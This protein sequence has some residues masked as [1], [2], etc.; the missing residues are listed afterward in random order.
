[1][2]RP[3]FLKLFLG[4]LTVIIIG[5]LLSIIF[6]FKAI[7]DY[8]F[9][10]T[11]DTMVERN[12]PLQ[13]EVVHLLA[14]HRER[15]LTS[16]VKKYGALNRTRITIIDPEGTVLAD[17]VVDPATMYNHRTRLEIAEA[18]QGRI[19][20]S[21]RF[22]PDLKEE[23]IYIALP[24]RSAGAVVGVI[25]YSLKSEEISRLLRTVRARIILVSVLVAAF[26]L[27]ISFIFSHLLSQPIRKLQQAAQK[28]AGGDFTVRV[29]ISGND[30]LKDL[31]AGFN[32]MTARIKDSFSEISRKQ[33]ELQGIISSIS[34]V[35]FLLDSEG[36]VLLCNESAKRITGLEKIIGKYYWE[37]LRSSFLHDMLKRKGAVHVSEEIPLNG[38]VY[39]C[40]ASSLPSGDATV[41]ILHDITDMK[42]MEQIKQDLVVNVSHELNT[43]LTAIKGFTETL[44]EEADE[45][46]LQYLVIIKR[47]TVRLIN[48]VKDLL[49]LSELEE[50][51]S[52]LHRE[53]VNL[54]ALIENLTVIFE[55]RILAKD[56]VLTVDIPATLTLAA[57]PFWL[58]QLFTNLIDNAIKY[59]EKGEITIAAEQTHDGC[60]ISIKDTGIGISKEHLGR[61]FERFY[62]VDKSRSRS[63]GGTGL[64]LAIVKHIVALHHGEIDVESTPYLG[65]TFTITL[66]GRM[67]E[68][69]NSPDP[70]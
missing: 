15:E 70:L 63:V 69:F 6:S 57:D 23:M 18:L 59:T 56:L 28:V 30:E 32:Q 12:R 62:V 16:L 20:R 34:E 60:R 11:T 1:M 24:V 14:E 4:F 21:V 26:S 61:I 8:Y 53:T 52:V 51:G 54:R 58:E 47:H 44:I 7:R 64:G 33:E 46:Q 31:A 3:I 67:S 10:S 65:T 22:S 37:L 27:I 38:R 19:G 29:P 55:P 42:Q 36:R 2:K 49:T 66:P 5:S 48:I 41:L 43:P 13:E 68:K 35:L 39:Q 40:N 50:K 17:S 25:R 9:Q 45:H